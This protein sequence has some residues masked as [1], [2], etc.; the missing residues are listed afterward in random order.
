MSLLAPWALWFGLI[1]AGVVALYLLKIKRRQQ[2]VPALDFWLDLAG[3]TK[4][5]SL[6]DRLKRLLSMLLW[7]AIVACL[8]LALGNPILALGRVKPRAIAVVF[9]NS[10]SM[11]TLESEGS[12]GEARTTRLELARRAL[13]DLTT[14]RPVT[15]EWLLIEAAREPRV[16]QSWT[17]D[18]KA[19]RTAATGI[20]PFAGSGDLPAAVA[21]AGQLLAGKPDP[22]IVVLSDG[23]AGAVAAL[24]E[25]DKRIVP[26]PIGATRDN[27]GIT[28]LAAR[29]H[30]QNGD[31]HVLISVANASDEPV[32]TRLTL[33]LDGSVHAVE[34]VNVEAGGT[35]EKTVV[36]DALP[37]GAA[38]GA[39]LRASL[40]RPDALALDN[41]A[42]ATLEP[43]RP[44][45]VWLV[46]EPEEAF[47]FEQA[48]GSMETLV[49]AEE[50]LTLAPE[51]YEHA[52]AAASR[53]TDAGGPPQLRAPDLVIFNNCAPPA[54]PASGRFVFLNAWPKEIPAA[55]SGRL[56]LPQLF[57]SSRAHPLTQHIS[58]QGVRLAAA[59]RITLPPGLTVLAHTA[60]G[61]PLMFLAEDPG[62][63]S[64]C[65]AFS[66]LE[67]DMPFRNAF[68][69]LLRNAVAHLHAEAP[70]WLRP[71]YRIGEPVR[72]ARPIPGLVTSVELTVLH[73]DADS[74]PR[75]LQVEDGSF[76]Y[77]GADRPGALRLSVGDER[78]LASVSIGD[79]AESLIAPIAS[80]EDP[81]TVLVLS[82]RLLGTMPW[83]G[84]AM[85]ASLLVALEWLTFHF[86]WTE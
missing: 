29:S 69:L 44:A 85:A 7:L 4:V 60:D 40:D 63:R 70:S 1:A 28:R 66:V 76:R 19:V 21:L 81:A 80:A 13:K 39:V 17:Y 30:R 9:D 26:W 23:A 58:V 38:D 45:V 53:T 22:C 54:L 61:D 6:F 24:A 31:H 16:L 55:A 25:A 68:P 62:R 8:V 20:E 75:T 10:A 43:I 11:Q 36:M 49:W 67:S 59:Q 15:D 56:E 52:V 14:R 57:L 48:L 2:A 78:A 46:T 18:A 12:G 64:L 65:L 42:Y 84:L 51:Q 86:R 83:L 3:R 72:P 34:L 73:A 74:G 33:E 47:F 35:W 79:P 41:E 5:H 77:T 82:G 27:L 32:E 37:G 50:S 71:E